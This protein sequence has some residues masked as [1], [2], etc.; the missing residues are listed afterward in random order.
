MTATKHK[1]PLG[2]WTALA[3]SRGMAGPVT[4]DYESTSSQED[5]DLPNEGDEAST[6]KTCRTPFQSKSALADVR[7]AS[8]SYSCLQ[9]H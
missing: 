9:L 5:E 4:A 7:A 8:S 6:C 1:S 2:I 3:A